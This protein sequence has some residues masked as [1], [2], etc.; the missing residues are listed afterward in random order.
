MKA[1]V[2]YT[3]FV[4]SNIYAAGQFD[5]AYNSRNIADAYG[6]H[7]ELL[8][9]AGMRAEKFLANKDPDADMELVRQAEENITRIAPKQLVLISTID[10][11]KSPAGVDETAIIDTDGLQAYGLNRYRLEQWVRDKYPD[12]LII[13]LPGLYGRNIKKN[14]I[15]DYLHI[16]PSM[17]RADK[18]AELAEH[19]P[20]LKQYYS[21]QP[22][23]FYK[24]GSLDA[25]QA[26]QLKNIFR[27]LGFTALCFTDSRSCYQFY[28]LFR[29]W[30]DIQTG[31][32]Q[33]L[34]LLHTATEP[35]SASELYT[36]LSGQEFVNETSAPPAKYDYR[37]KYATLFG[38]HNGYLMDK[39]EVLSDIKRF[40]DA[41]EG[42]I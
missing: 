18:F 27:T 16:I 15:Y 33:Q 34:P 28:P 41:M 42:K 3:G 35:V 32:R 19:E 14:F 40:V 6:T 36:F 26:E 39:S 13:R 1:I 22:N 37:T 7:P 25:H 23:G 29:L 38:G 9:Y 8:I 12:A 4:G 2:G 30:D 10:V 31:L 11:L 5:A 24:C 17:L 20:V 21:L